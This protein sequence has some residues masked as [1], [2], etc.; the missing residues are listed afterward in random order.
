L[1]EEAINSTIFVINKISHLWAKEHQEALDDFQDF[2]VEQNLTNPVYQCD[3]KQLSQDDVKKLKELSQEVQPFREEEFEG[4]RM[5]IYYDRFLDAQKKDEQE[6][7]KQEDIEREVGIKFEKRSN[8]MQTKFQED[9]RNMEERHKI[10]L[11][12]HEAV[13]NDK[14]LKLQE[15]YQS[16]VNALTEKSNQLESE[17]RQEKER[18]KREGEERE[19]K[20]QEESTRK[21]KDSKNFDLPNFLLE[22]LPIF[23]NLLIPNYSRLGLNFK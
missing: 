6:K 14:T 12:K 1:G 18:S 20:R 7:K 13:N 17:I 2:L 3:L 23:A 16:K 15:K 21:N 9:A 10:A 5:M 11:Q 22:A 19:R 8:E 4:H